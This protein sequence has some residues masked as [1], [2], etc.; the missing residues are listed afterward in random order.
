MSAQ[1]DDGGAAFPL[2]LP[3]DEG[4]IRHGMTLRDW[5]AGQALPQVFCAFSKDVQAELE[6]VAG[7]NLNPEND[8]C[9][10]RSWMTDAHDSEWAEGIANAC[11]NIAD[12][13]LKAR[14]GGER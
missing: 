12:A 5:F 1:I 7:S 11:Y 10:L 2:Y 3:Q 14:K 6:E 9:S 4:D 13:M 8:G